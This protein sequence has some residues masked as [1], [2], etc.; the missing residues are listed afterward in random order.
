VTVLL[1][2]EGRYTDESELAGECKPTAVVASLTEF[3]SLLREQFELLA[4]AGLQQQEQQQQM[5]QSA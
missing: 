5:Q 4:P 2:T 3:L 1:D